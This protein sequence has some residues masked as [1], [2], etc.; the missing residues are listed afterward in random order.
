MNMMLEYADDFRYKV[1][2]DVDKVG[3]ISLEPVA[4]DH[5]VGIT[6]IELNIDAHKIFIA[7]ERS[8]YEV[9]RF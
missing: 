1:V 9:V 6:V 2:L 8:L 4:P 7:T 3:K 5:L